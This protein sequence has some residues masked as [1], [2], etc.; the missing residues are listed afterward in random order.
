MFRAILLL[1]A[2][3]VLAQSADL[4]GVWVWE[5]TFYGGAVAPGSS[6]DSG[7]WVR[8]AYFEFKGRGGTYRD[9]SGGSHSIDNV[10]VKGDKITFYTGHKGGGGEDIHTRWEG[11]IRANEIKGNYYFDDGVLGE[12]LLKRSTSR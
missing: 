2:A 1:L 11:V 5:R 6:G 3:G 10:V 4:S 12:F 8:K 7:P 9:Y